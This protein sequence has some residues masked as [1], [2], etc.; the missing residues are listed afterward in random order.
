LGL[1]D[2]TGQTGKT[3]QLSLGGLGSMARAD[4]KAQP[5]LS[6]LRGCGARTARMAFPVPL[7]GR[8]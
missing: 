2:S 7:E 1:A 5:E 8:A 4:R 6:V 3:R